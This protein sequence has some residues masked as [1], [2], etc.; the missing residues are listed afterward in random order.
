M[1]VG[2]LYNVGD[3]RFWGDDDCGRSMVFSDNSELFFGYERGA[4]LGKIGS[5][6]SSVDGGEVKGMAEQDKVIRSDMVFNK[7]IDFP[8][9]MTIQREAVFCSPAGKAPR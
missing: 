6:E 7:I 5:P 1:P 9:W 3:Y 2:C 4:E 8:V